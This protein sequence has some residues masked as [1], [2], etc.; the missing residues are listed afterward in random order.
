MRLAKTFSLLASTLTLLQSLSLAATNTQQQDE[1]QIKLGLGVNTI[2]RDIENSDLEDVTTIIVEAFSP[3]ADWHY[4]VPEVDKPEYKSQLWRCM[5]EE[6]I[7]SWNKANK[8]TS[9]G[10]VITVPDPAG[11]MGDR[12]VALGIW[13]I[14][15]R[16]EALD[17]QKQD[18]FALGNSLLHVTRSCDPLPGLN[19]T[20]GEDVERQEQGIME[21][22]FY[23]AYEK[24]LY[25]NL[26][27]THPD[28][29]GNGF[30]ARHCNWGMILAQELD[31][32]LTLFA[33]PAGWPLYDSLGFESVK[34]VTTTMLDSLGTLWHEVMRW[35]Y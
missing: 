21:K 15:T 19:V 23:E 17:F 11:E 12:A 29:D 18:V 5:H 3:S 7:H 25:L 31:V 2:F 16:D 24:Q 32:P 27:A 1:S 8:S 13:V 22:Y 33:T 20:R 10:K 30:G 26:L 4:L 6:I 9:F 35:N 14:L 28:W 34:N